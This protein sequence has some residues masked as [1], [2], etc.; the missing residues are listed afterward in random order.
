MLGPLLRSGALLAALA[1]ASC[2]PSKTP[3]GAEPDPD[4]IPDAFARPS[5]ALMWPGA[6]RAFEVTPAGDVT[7]GV[8]VVRIGLETEGAAAA[9]PRRIAA[10]ERWLPVL[11]WMR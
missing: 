7:N 5:G 9:P 2:R 10:E 1:I 6:H 4:T 3:A 11:H 8:W